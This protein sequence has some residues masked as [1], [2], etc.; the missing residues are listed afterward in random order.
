MVIDLGGYTIQQSEDFYLLQR[1]FNVIELNDRVFVNNK[2]SP[3]SSTRRVIRK[4]ISSN[5]RLNNRFPLRF[6]D[7]T[8]VICILLFYISPAGASAKAG[9]IV[10]PRNVVIKNG[11]LGRSSHAGIHGNSVEGLVVENVKI[12][13][14]E[15][16]GIQCNGCR[17]VLITS[18]EVGPSAHNVPV[19]AT[20]SNARF[21][22][23]FTKRLIPS[24]FQHEPARQ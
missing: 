4:C 10:T 15:V 6:I 2:A 19:L 5:K 21:L 20:F 1:F 18:S 13:N 16:A 14:F 22:E 24:G 11:S 17:D 23:F 7:L 3:R 9:S 8:P 12:S